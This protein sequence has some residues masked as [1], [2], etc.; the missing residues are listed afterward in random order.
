MDRYSL[1]RSAG[2][3]GG[4]CFYIQTSLNPKVSNTSE[5]IE[6][7]WVTI[8]LASLS[9]SLGVVYR[10]ADVGD[11]GFID[12]LEESLSTHNTTSD[13]VLCM[14][15]I[16]IDMLDVDGSA[17]MRFKDMFNALDFCQV[18]N[19]P[20]RGENDISP[21][22]PLLNYVEEIS[23]TWKKAGFGEEDEEGDV[24][25]LSDLRERLRD[26]ETE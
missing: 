3:G 8:R 9:V 1:F 23:I 26:K 22:I 25:P 13:H 7:L 19:E 10:P 16:N 2:R 18:I 6:Q 15:D 21:T 17:T 24:I 5:V 11:G 12:H 14:G 20:T 4:V